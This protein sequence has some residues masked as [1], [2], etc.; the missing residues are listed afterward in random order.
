M[1]V[2]DLEAPLLDFWVAKAEGLADLPEKQGQVQGLDPGREYYRPSTYHPSTDWSQGGPIVS[3]QWFELES[4]LIEWFGPRWPFLQVFSSSP[5]KWFMRA[6]VARVFGDE[7]ED[8]DDE[9]DD[10]LDD[11]VLDDD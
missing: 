4:H 11:E 2:A 3:R 7:V 9:D 10:Y 8:F 5:L 6:H 1:R